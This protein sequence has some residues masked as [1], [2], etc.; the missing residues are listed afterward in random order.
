MKKYAMNV[1]LMSTL[2]LASEGVNIDE[3][4]RVESERNETEALVR[5][6]LEEQVPKGKERAHEFFGGYFREARQEEGSPAA[7]LPQ[8]KKDKS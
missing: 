3:N 1:C 8:E 2:A 4:G 6:M 7:T 5:D